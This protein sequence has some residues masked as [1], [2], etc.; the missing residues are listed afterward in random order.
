MQELIYNYSLSLDRDYM[1]IRP[2]DV[3]LTLWKPLIGPA[4]AQQR[5]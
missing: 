3:S 5:A 4:M 2:T 1:K